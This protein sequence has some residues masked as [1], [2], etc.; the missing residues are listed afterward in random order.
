M[1]AEARRLAETK[2]AADQEHPPPPPPPRNA[3]CP[4]TPTPGSS[5]RGTG[6]QPRRRARRA[7]PGR[8]GAAP[9]GRRAGPDAGRVHVRPAVH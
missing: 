6:A 8:P 4:R 2:D 7:L 9:G 1:T 3:F 5:W